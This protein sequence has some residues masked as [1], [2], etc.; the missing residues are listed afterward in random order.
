M[1]PAR[2]IVPLRPFSTIL[3]IVASA[4]LSVFPME[5]P[6]DTVYFP[7]LYQVRF[8]GREIGYVNGHGLTLSS[9][10][11]GMTWR[12]NGFI[13]ADNIKLRSFDERRLASLSAIK[14][15][16]RGNISLRAVAAA[17]P[18][19]FVCGDSGFIAR[20]SDNERSWDRMAT[21]TRQAL[22]GIAFINDDDARPFLRCGSVHSLP[23]IITTAKPSRS[24]KLS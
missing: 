15:L 14:T 23:R 19:T 20:S 4:A 13:G 8:P 21:P 22:H 3:L 16:S 11:Q 18:R 7:D 10:N 6:K 5:K 9:N 1:P 17:G 2:S 24:S 12:K